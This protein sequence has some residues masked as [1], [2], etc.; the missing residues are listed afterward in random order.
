MKTLTVATVALVLFACAA[1]EPT[2]ESRDDA[3]TVEHESTLLAHP[4]WY[5]TVGLRNN[6]GLSWLVQEIETADG[7]RLV[8]AFRTGPRGMAR[9][10][11]RGGLGAP[12]VRTMRVYPAEVDADGWFVHLEENADGSFRSHESRWINLDY[13][14]PRPWSARIVHARR[15]LATVW[16]IDHEGLRMTL[17]GVR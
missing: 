14:E 3:P 12:V 8:E 9:D 15:D 1:C 5:V 6:S 7:Q 11:H 4:H 10:Y 13:R 16:R 2:R 17:D